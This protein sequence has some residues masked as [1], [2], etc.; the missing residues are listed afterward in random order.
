MR[1]I[2]I[3][4][5]LVILLP[6]PG[7][8]SERSSYQRAKK[9]D[10]VE[11]YDEF[12]ERYPNGKLAT[13]A[14]HRLEQLKMVRSSRL[15]ELAAERG[16]VGQVRALLDE[17]TSPNGGSVLF[18]PLH[19]AVQNGHIETVRLLISRGA[20]VNAR[21]QR[22]VTPLFTLGIVRVYSKEYRKPE[23]P[24]LETQREIASLLV[25]HG[26]VECTEETMFIVGKGRVGSV[27]SCYGRGPEFYDT[28]GNRICADKTKAQ[29]CF[30]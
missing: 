10:T 26:A 25:A 7:L 4:V 6:L 29:E 1:S 18:T 30:Q 17:G 13:E 3:T 5:A 2:V 19:Y 28:A 24:D 11:A 16:D 9:T 14:E 22:G 12:L 8:A 20:D 15:L 21:D 23:A 27:R